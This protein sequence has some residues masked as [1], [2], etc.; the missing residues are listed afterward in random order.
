MK[1][2][3]PNWDRLKKNLDNKVIT[4]KG[5]A[6]DQGS[7]IPDLVETAVASP[8]IKEEKPRRRKVPRVRNNNKITN[9]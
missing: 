7:E 5:E 2:M 1:A 8:A 6:P 3:R 9:W 4:L